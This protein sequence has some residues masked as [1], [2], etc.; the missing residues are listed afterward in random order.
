MIGLKEIS[1]AIHHLFDIV[2]LDVSGFN[3]L[4]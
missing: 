2:L 1:L 3:D 4:L